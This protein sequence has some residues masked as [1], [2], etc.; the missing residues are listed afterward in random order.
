MNPLVQSKRST[1]IHIRSK[2]AQDLSNGQYNTNF[3]VTVMNPIFCLPEEEL[4]I[5]VMSCELP[6]SWY[7]ISSELFNDTLQFDTGNTLT[8]TS[9][10]YSICDLIYYL[11][12]DSNASTFST[13]FNTT[14]NGQR[15]KITFTNKTAESHTIDLSVS[16]INKVIGWPETSVDVTVVAGGSVTSPGVC[17]M[18]TVHSVMIKCSIGQGNVISTRAGNSAILQ[19]VSVDENSTGIVYLNQQDFRQ[20]SVSQS[21][22]IDTMDFRFTDQNDNLLQCNGCNFEFTM[23]F[24]VFPKYSDGGRRTIGSVSA[25]RGVPQIPTQE[26]ETVRITDTSIDSSHP[27]TDTTEIEHKSSRLILDALIDRIS[28]NT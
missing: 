3:R 11:N 7:N 18:A 20:I 14:Y 8:L 25:Q 19:K 17:N 15:N 6:Y 23:L 24:E 10:D 1:I 16:N 21:P 13:I 2:D 28:K 27:I 4:H 26:L 12:N 9:Q 22:I 5:S